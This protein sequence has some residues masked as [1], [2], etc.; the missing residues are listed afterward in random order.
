MSRPSPSE[1]LEVSFRDPGY[2]ERLRATVDQFVPARATVVPLYWSGHEGL[3]AR[4]RRVLHFSSSFDGG[5]EPRVP[6]PPA[7]A[8]LE[9]LRRHGAEY[10]VVPGPALPWLEG[11]PELYGYLAGSTRELVWRP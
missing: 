3:D 4:D 9:E 10:F 6:G 5:G 11:Q 1:V 8:R 7:L 2:A